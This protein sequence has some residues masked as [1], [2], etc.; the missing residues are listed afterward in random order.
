MP[1]GGIFV[2]ETTQ[3]IDESPRGSLVS[4]DAPIRDRLKQ[5]HATEELA[6]RHKVSESLPTWV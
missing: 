5:R 2:S 1:V 6:S 3:S 4:R